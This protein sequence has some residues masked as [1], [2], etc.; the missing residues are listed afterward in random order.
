[1]PITSATRFSALAAVTINE[2]NIAQIAK[3]HS[4]RMGMAPDAAIT[5]WRMI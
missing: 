2:N 4:H 3:L 5:I 1:L